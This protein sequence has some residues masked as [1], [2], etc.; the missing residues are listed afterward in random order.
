MSSFLFEAINLGIYLSLAFT[1]YV[2]VIFNW[3]KMDQW[4][5]AKRNPVP[6]CPIPIWSILPQCHIF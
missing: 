5:G 1:I 2:Y 3:G 6:F 4:L